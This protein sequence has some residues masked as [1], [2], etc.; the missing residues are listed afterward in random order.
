MVNTETSF[1]QLPKRVINLPHRTDRLKRFSMEIAS[2]RLKS[3]VLLVPGVVVQ[4]QPSKGIGMAHVAAM[5]SDK[6]IVVVFEDD[7][8]FPGRHKTI[9]HIDE[10]LRNAPKDWDVLLGGALNL[11]VKSQY[12]EHWDIVED[13]RG[14]QFYIIKKSAV[15]RVKNEYKFNDHIDKWISEAG[16]KVYIMRTI[17]CMQNDGFSDNVKYNTKYYTLYSK[18]FNILKP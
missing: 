5:D 17:V 4:E 3:F 11:K 7:A 12:N 6:P 9:P 13:F 15:E 8:V 14:L 2:I 1:E 16:F 10:C 18:R